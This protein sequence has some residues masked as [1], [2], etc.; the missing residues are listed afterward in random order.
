MKKSVLGCWLLIIFSAW[1]TGCSLEPIEVETDPPA[2]TISF[3]PQNLTVRTYSYFSLEV[4]INSV[5]NIFG[6]GLDIKY[7]PV[8]FEWIR[9]SNENS[10]LSENSQVFLAAAPFLPGEL[11]FAITRLGKNSGSVSGPGLVAT[12]TFKSLNQRGQSRISFSKNHI[13]ILEED[14]SHYFKNIDQQA[15]LIKVR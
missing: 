7:D 3:S 14:G 2:E 1:L 9:V 8:F 6:V 11:S 15:A 13:C 4:K 12:L 10:F 5:E